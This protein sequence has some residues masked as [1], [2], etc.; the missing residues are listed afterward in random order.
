MSKRKTPNRRAPVSPGVVVGLAWYT[1]DQWQ[2]LIEIADDRD[3]LD[4]T[5][6]Q[7]LRSARKMMREMLRLGQPVEKVDVDVEELRLWCQAHG[8][9]VTGEARS[10]YVAIRLRELH[11]G[12]SQPS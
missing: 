3:S 5:Y 11:G 1:P 6:E 2:R 10:R 8:D 4:E 9:A 7:W 12:S